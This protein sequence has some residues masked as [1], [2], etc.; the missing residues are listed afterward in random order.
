MK[1]NKR[2]T[3]KFILIW[4]LILLIS[5]VFFT[6]CHECGH[7]FGSVFEGVSVSTSFNRVGNAGKIPHDP[8]F[9]DG[10]Y[11]QG[12]LTPGS[13]M[14]PFVSWTFAVMFTILLTNLK[15]AG[16]K[17]KV[18]LGS[19]AIANAWCR[20]GSTAWILIAS[21]FGHVHMED[22]VEW[23][24]RSISSLHFPMATDAFSALAK[25]NPQILLSHPMYY[26]WPL[27][28]ML[29]S[30]ICFIAAFRYLLQNL[31]Q[32]LNDKISRIVFVASP[33]LLAP[34]WF[35]VINTLDNL[36]RINW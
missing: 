33:L 30:L 19:C 18:L 21:L 28:S 29:I 22:E 35:I 24:G 32:Y 8:D 3:V 15:K 20:L 26:F 1:T 27:F 9:R 7:G 13:F 17:E 16:T 23:F 2:K 10:Q 6:F 5:M 4:L 36:I 34:V 11:I 31:K 25:S 12:M 14:G